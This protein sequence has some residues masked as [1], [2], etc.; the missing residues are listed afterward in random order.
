[1]LFLDGN[2]L[3]YRALPGAYTADLRQAV[4]DRRPELVALLVGWDQTQAEIALA[5][6]LG[7]CD[8]AAKEARTDGQRRAV[9][10]YRA[11]VTGLAERLDPYLFAVLP[12]LEKVFARWQLWR[13]E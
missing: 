9:D 1:R 6:A 3:R 8:R 4:A 12:D 13:R 5:A 7:R 11:A 10:A 2:R